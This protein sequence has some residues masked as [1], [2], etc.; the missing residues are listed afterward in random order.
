MRQSKGIAALYMTKSDKK[1]KPP[2]T[3]PTSCRFIKNLYMH[4]STLSEWSLTIRAGKWPATETL[5]L[6]RP[7][8]A[9]SEKVPTVCKHQTKTDRTKEIRVV[10]YRYF[11]GL[12]TTET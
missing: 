2:K 8:K 1:E 6:Y 7:Q 5:F 3:H 9:A 11:T 4:I 10:S 12:A